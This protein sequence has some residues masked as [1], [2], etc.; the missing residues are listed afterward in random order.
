MLIAI[1]HGNKLIKIPNH[2]PFTSGLQESDSPP[3][4]GETLMYQGKYYTLS[5]KRIPYHRDKT[6]DERFWIL[7]LFAIAYEIEAVGGYSRDLMRVDLAV[8]LPPA[9]FGAQHRAFAQ[10]FSQRGAVKFEFHKREFAVYIGK[11]LCFPQTYAAAVTVLKTLRDK[12]KAIII[13]QGGMT[14]DYLMLKEGSADD[15]SRFI[16]ITSQNEGDWKTLHD[17]AVSDIVA[18][19]SW[20]RTLSGLDYGEVQGER[21]AG[22]I[23]GGIGD[24]RHPQRPH[25]ARFAPGGRHGGAAGPGVRQRPVQHPPGAGTGASLG[26]RRVRRRRLHPAVPPDR[27][28]GEGGRSTVHQ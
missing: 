9:H 16:P 2:A 10:Y 15:N 8:G 3:F 26:R 1:D 12:P 6:E 25:G 5:E 18:A 20:F 22:R 7:T 14:T 21:G 13:D 28:V 19:H 24:R 11:V 4:G 17:Q 23:A 27:G